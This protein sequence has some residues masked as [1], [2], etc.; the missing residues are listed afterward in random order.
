MANNAN[1]ASYGTLDIA[2]SRIVANTNRAWH[3]AGVYLRNH[4]N[5]NTVVDCVIASDICATN[6]GGGIYTDNYSGNS[7]NATSL[8]RNCW[9]EATARRAAASAGRRI[10]IGTGITEVLPIVEKK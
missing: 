4:S 10:H 6:T 2:R 3:S 8:F 9:S 5:L 7:G 1:T